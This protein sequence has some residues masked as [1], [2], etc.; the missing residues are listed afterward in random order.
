[1]DDR[2]ARIIEALLQHLEEMDAGD[3]RNQMKPPV[4]DGVMVAKVDESPDMGMEPKEEG[5]MEQLA[6]HGKDPKSM[7]DDEDMSEEELEE[8]AK[9]NC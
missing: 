9:L 6:K 1:M 8:M 4:A 3:M 5:P 7:M 2:K